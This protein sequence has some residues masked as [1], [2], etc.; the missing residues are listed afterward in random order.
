M[1]LNPLNSSSLRTVWPSSNTRKVKWEQSGAGNP[2]S[3]LATLH[4]YWSAI[5]RSNPMRSL[6]VPSPIFLLTFLVYSSNLTS[7]RRARIKGYLWRSTRNPLLLWV[8]V[9]PLSYFTAMFFFSKHNSM[10]CSAEREVTRSFKALVLKIV[11][12]EPLPK[13]WPRSME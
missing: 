4:F 10:V 5:N 11:P 8:R 1:G 2:S 7:W 6:G 13:I 12:K 9:S 3:K